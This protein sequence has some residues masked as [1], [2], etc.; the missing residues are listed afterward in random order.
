MGILRHLPRVRKLTLKGN[1][2]IYYDYSKAPKKK[3]MMKEYRR[4][5]EGRLLE[6][7]HKNIFDY[8]TSRH[9]GISTVPFVAIDTTRYAYGVKKVYYY[10]IFKFTFYPK[11]QRYKLHDPIT[12]TFYYKEY[13]LGIVVRDYFGKYDVLIG[14]SAAYFLEGLESLLASV[15]FSNQRLLEK[16]VPKNRRKWFMRLFEESYT[17]NE[18]NKL[19]L[20]LKFSEN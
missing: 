5:T 15:K 17:K 3:W 20:L 7:T 16:T 19:N 6:F 8:V 10:P 9:L 12:D 2:P 4:R 14:Y 1:S 13:P 11:L 18:A